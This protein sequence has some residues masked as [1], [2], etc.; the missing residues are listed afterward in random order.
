MHL[1]QIVIFS[2]LAIPW[3]PVVANSANSYQDHSSIQQAVE[4]FVHD[5]ITHLPHEDVQVAIGRI[6]ARLKLTKCQQPLDVRSISPFN[7]AGRN[8]LAISCDLPRHWKIHV[9]VSLKVFE[10]V[11]VA[12]TPL[13]RGQILRAADLATERK[14]ISRITGGFYTNIGELIGKQVKH[15]IRLGKVINQNAVVYPKI[16][17]RGQHV[18]IRAKNSTIAVEASGKALMDGA[19]GDQIQVSNDNSKRVVEAVITGPGI[20]EIDI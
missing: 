14:E 20:V 1:K 18:T 3:L 8:N 6:D 19:L 12:A 7:P 11:I 2:F 5:E 16:I 9:P 10:A 13:P 4:N 15:P 17:K